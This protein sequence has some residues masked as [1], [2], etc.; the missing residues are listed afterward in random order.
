MSILIDPN[1][2]EFHGNRT[3]FDFGGVRSAAHL[4]RQPYRFASVCH[5]SRPPPKAKWPEQ[6]RLAQR[7]GCKAYGRRGLMFPRQIGGRV[8]SDRPPP[9]GGTLVFQK[10]IKP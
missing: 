1:S 10:E 7:L 2:S 8:W 5:G 9:A 3:D 4:P 6:P